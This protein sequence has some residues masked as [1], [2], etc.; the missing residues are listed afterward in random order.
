MTKV[1]SAIDIARTLRAALVGTT[2]AV[3]AVVTGSHVATAQSAPFIY[4]SQGQSLDQQAGDEAACRSWSQQQTGFNPAQGPIYY[5]SSGSSGGEVIGGAAR[6][7]ALGVIGGAIGGNA[8]KGAAIGAG[9]DLACMCDLRVGSERAAFG[10]TFVNLGI[11][12]GDGGGWLVQR[13]IGYAKAAEMT[14]TGRIVKAEEALAII[15]RAADGS[16]C[17][18][19]SLLD[20]A[21]ALSGGN[22]IPA[23][24][25]GRGSSLT[26]SRFDPRSTSRNCRSRALAFWNRIGLRVTRETYDVAGPGRR[27]PRITGDGIATSGR[28]TLLTSQVNAPMNVRLISIAALMFGPIL[29]PF[30]GGNRLDPFHQLADGRA[31]SRA[32]FAA[33]VSPPFSP[34]RAA[35]HCGN[36]GS[37][38]AHSFRARSAYASESSL[39]PHWPPPACV[40]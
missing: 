21:I 31:E 8:G 14:F 11:I 38:D 10:E 5:S 15:A 22:V 40:S 17:D 3:A 7:A 6:G 2:F 13:L 30:R 16:V 29:K 39:S 9:C 23:R 1:P 18:G 28:E 36:A 26:T 12:P 24:I 33:Y 19:L 25:A 37:L 4:P 35:W 34:R 32:A 27:F 20:Q